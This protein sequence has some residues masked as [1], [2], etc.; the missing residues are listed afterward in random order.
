MVSC[1]SVFVRTISCVSFNLVFSTADTFDESG[2]CSGIF[3]EEFLPIVGIRVRINKDN[4]Q[5][6]VITKFSLVF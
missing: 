5:W 6:V 3:P 2:A 1:K 4:Q